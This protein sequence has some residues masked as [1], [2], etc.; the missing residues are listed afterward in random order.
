MSQRQQHEEKQIDFND[1]KPQKASQTQNQ[2]PSQHQNPTY[3][4]SQHDAIQQPINA[5]ELHRRL[6]AE[7]DKTS[8]Q[9][10]SES[11]KKRKQASEGL[12]SEQESEEA[13]ITS[14]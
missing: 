5:D 12:L 1:E 3:W 7:N 10:A 14:P 11:A 13:E 9:R 4:R 8:R 2:N 6:Q